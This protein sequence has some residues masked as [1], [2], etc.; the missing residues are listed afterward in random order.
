MIES[1]TNPLIK[2]I[3]RLRKCKGNRAVLEGH[4]LVSE[5]L[6]AGLELETTLVSPDFQ[7]RP[8]GSALVARLPRPPLEVTPSLLRDLS[9]VDSP[10]GVLAVVTLPRPSVAELPVEKHGIYLFVDRLQDPGN[11]GALIRVGEA[12]GVQGV[13]LSPGC[14]HPNHPRALRASAGSLLRLAVA[15]ECPADAL[16]RHLAP[17][18]A[19]WAALVPR[20]GLPLFD[21]ELSRPLVVAVGAEGSGLS[22]DLAARAEQRLTIPLAGRVESLNSTVAAAVVL[23]EIRRRATPLPVPPGS[24]PEPLPEDR[25]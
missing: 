7:K 18:A 4:H 24:G 9:D 6:E 8:E 21:T 12:T 2:D 25:R 14:A 17:V 22:A 19:T 20:D 1:R 15:R 16:R 23:Y 10:Q 3:R 11:L 13:A 5:A